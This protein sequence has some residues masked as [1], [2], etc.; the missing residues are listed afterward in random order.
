M[1]TYPEF[2]PPSTQPTRLM[3]GARRVFCSLA[4][5]AGVSIF[6]WT[7]RATAQ[8]T[9][10]AT[11]PTITTE[12]T[13]AAPK[14]RKSVLAQNGVHETQPLFPRLDLSK[15][16]DKRGR[17]TSGDRQIGHPFERLDNPLVI[18]V[19]NT[20]SEPVEGVPIHFLI[21]NQP[22][23]VKRGALVTPDSDGTDSSGLYQAS[24][25][26]GDAIGPY[27]ILFY[28]T[29]PTTARLN[30]V[31]FS[32]E[33]KSR[34]WGNMLLLE[35]LGGMAIFLYGILL[36]SEGLKAVAGTRF[37][38]TVATM[39][40]SD[41]RGV[42]LGI[43][44]TF[45][46]QSSGATT[47]MLISF[48]RARL[49]TFRQCLG[50]IIGAA[51][52]TTI[53]VQ[54]ISFKLDAY[55]LPAIAVGFILMIAAKDRRLVSI[56][57]III[58]FA[59]IFYGMKVMSGAVAPLKNFGWFRGIL[60]G[61][62]E[63]PFWSMVLATF[64]TG[65]IH[66]SAATIGIAIS[67]A[68]QDLIT[69]R[70]AIPIIFGANIGTTVTA[71]MASVGGSATSKRVAWS[72]LLYKIIGVT[73]FFPLIAVLAWLGE[74]LSVVLS[75][76]P[77][78]SA[79]A[80]DVSRQIANTHTLFNILIALIFLPFLNIFGKFLEFLFPGKKKGPEQQ[81]TKYLVDAETVGDTHVVFGSV[82]REISRMAR[83]VE[84]M[85][86][87]V[88]PAMFKKDEKALEFVRLRD[89]KVDMLQKHITRYLAD[90]SRHPLNEKEQ[91]RCV[92]LLFAVSDLENIGDII[93][94]NLLKV[95]EKIIQFEMTFSDEGFKELKEIH[96]EVSDQLSRVIIAISTRDT[97]IADNVCQEWHRLRDKGTNLHLRH[98][99]RLQEGFEESF[100]TS[101]VHLDIL[102]YLMR[103]EFHIY[104]VAMVAAERTDKALHLPPAKS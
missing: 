43:V 79:D 73:I 19:R 80:T 75:S 92:G 42:L 25:V 20:R 5:V 24:V 10:E 74:H 49:L 12:K 89:D 45:F 30:M 77:F 84:E 103:I 63:H 27:E 93:D 15:P 21:I 100:E 4:L 81:E 53:T 16:A 68:H 13:V 29:P 28:T 54:L 57:K 56:G 88:G 76:L 47:V 50:I 38:D 36:G 78:L 3:S 44:I 62:S 26:L 51:V 104:N 17:D 72:Y 22:E 95:A 70:A 61:L 1:T 6:A 96:R 64:F 40:K 23:S 86:Q 8:D 52:G 101:S 33:A 41:W 87:H 65:M 34:N 18:A 31:K 59:F 94:R 7:H 69:L 2:N 46:T 71:M 37:R 99:R 83:F 35:L 85:M 14:E 102:N 97:V 91:E 48:V 66:A 55:A 58:G 60:L 67:L 9:T 32:V 39:T 82:L 90:L 11:T 98:L